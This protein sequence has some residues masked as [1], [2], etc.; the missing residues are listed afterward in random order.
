MLQ[1]FSIQEMMILIP[2]LVVAFTIHELSHG[3]MAYAL[4]DS[5]AKHDGRLTLNP[6]KHIDPVGFICILLFQF[7]W[8]K[9]V[10]INTRN[11]KN[12]KVDMALIAFAGPL[13][14][15]IM[16]FLSLIGLQIFSPIIFAGPE[17]L[18]Y[19]ILQFIWLN[20]IL[21]IF[22]LIPIPPL[23]GSKILGGVLPNRLYMKYMSIGRVGM[24]LMLLA[25][26]TGMTR[27]VIIPA[28]SAV[29]RTFTII[30][31]AIF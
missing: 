14:N 7:G 4:G 24:M 16:A 25:M 29:F 26:F 5:T 22:N 8:A 27:M 9:P 21:G 28:A 17:F 1:G 10:M 3:L 12:P 15:F 30:V 13:S 18:F 31:G 11:L 2:A 20:I 23:D 6:I 19:V